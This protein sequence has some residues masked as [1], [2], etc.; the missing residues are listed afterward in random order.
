MAVNIVKVTSKPSTTQLSL[1]EMIGEVSQYNPDA[2]PLMVRRWIQNVN[3]RVMDYRNWYGLLVK[4]QIDVPDVVTGGSVAVTNASK[5]VTGTGTAFTSAMVGR[6]WRIGFSFPIYTI[7]SVQSA[8]QLTLDLPWGDADRTNSSYNIFQ[9]I[10]AIPGIKMFFAVVNQK[11]GYRLKLHIPQEV[12]NIYDTWRTTTGWTFLVADH[13]PSK[14][15]EPQYELYPAPTFQQ[16]FP[17][18]AYLQPADMKNDGDFPHPYIRSDVLVSGA[19][20]H[21]LR[22]RGKNSQYYDPQTA[23]YYDLI[24][25]QEVQNMAQMDNNV[26][27]RDMVWEFSRYPFTQHGADFWQSHDPDTM[28]F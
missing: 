19:I 11:Q 9:N 2:P 15:G 10:V 21:A 1:R 27:Q 28:P 5:I 25:R 6:Q 14:S 23:N 7:D 12:I 22:F 8:T 24:F 18:L 3:R 20:P 17:F 4:G 13:V 26:A 16:S